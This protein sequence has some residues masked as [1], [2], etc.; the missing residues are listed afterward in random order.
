MASIFFK[1]NGDPEKMSTRYAANEGGGFH[2]VTGGLT[3]KQA[4]EAG[5]TH[6]NLGTNTINQTDHMEREFKRMA[7]PVAKALHK[8]S[9]TKAQFEYGRPSHWN[10][11]EATTA[12]FTADRPHGIPVGSRES[13]KGGEVEAI[14]NT[15]VKA[16]IRIK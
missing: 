3:G 9:P 16:Y 1:T 12:T 15:Q 13:F 10:L 8:A 5:R 6:V 7:D 2:N 4:Q 11:D 14:N